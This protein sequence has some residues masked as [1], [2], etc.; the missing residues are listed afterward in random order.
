LSSQELSGK[1]FVTGSKPHTSVTLVPPGAQAVTLVGNL[2]RELARLSGAEV[3]VRGVEG[4][5]APAASFEVESYDVTRIDGEVPQVGVLAYVRGSLTLLG[6][7][8]LAL[9]NV[10]ED[11]RTHMGSKVWIVGPNENGKIV[12][13]SYGILRERR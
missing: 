9:S 6:A 10:P 1:V 12:V 7:D 13:Q 5:K 4:G 3:R 8:T 11:L 2:R